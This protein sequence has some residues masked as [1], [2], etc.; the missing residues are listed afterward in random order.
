M[1]DTLQEIERV[2]E[3]ITNTQTPEASAGALIDFFLNIFESISQ[4]VNPA[5]AASQAKEVVAAN[6]PA[7]ATAVAANP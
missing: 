5:A 1:G 4:A 7:L 3:A 2:T 6:K